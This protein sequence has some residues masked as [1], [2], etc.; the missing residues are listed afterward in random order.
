MNTWQNNLKAWEKQP[1]LKRLFLKF[2]KAEA[3]LVGGAVRDAIL[4]R[5]TK[6]FDLVIRQVAK[7]DLEKFLATQG[8]VNLVGKH[9]GVYKFRPRNWT[10]EEIDIA[11]PRTEYSLNQSGA[12]RDFKI[13]SQANLKIEDDLSRR[14]FTINAMAWDIKNKKI[15]DPFF[16]QSDLQ[17]K[18]IRTVGRPELRFKEDYS[19]LLRALRFSCQLSREP[20]AWEIE[21]TA[22]TAIKKNIKNLDKKI[23]GQ[24][25]VAYEVIAKELVKMVVSNPIWAIELLD[26][27]G[28]IKI[29]FPQLLKSKNCPQPKIYHSEG[30]VWEHMILAIQTLFTK[31]FKKEFKKPA[32]QEVIWAVIFHDIGKPFTLTMADRIRFNNH[33]VYSTNLFGQLSDKLKLTSAGLDVD[34]VKKLINK[35]MLTVQSQVLAMKDVTLEKYFFNPQF[36]GDELLMVM[37]AD[38]T[39]TVPPS[40]QPDYSSY[41]IL[42]KRLARLG[43]ANKNKKTLPKPLVTGGDLIKKFKLNSSPKIGDLLLI[44]REAQLKGKIKTKAQGLLFI[45][46]HIK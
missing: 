26:Q 42:K 33:D 35:H 37:F 27:C 1:F 24:R 34:K 9:F 16:G 39:A 43:K 2:P 14:D 5:E 21:T 17:Q 41:R 36:P 29:L 4:G 18:I 44:L 45:K 6:D 15:I 20:A 46:K 10:G 23:D 28:A 40:G 38:I 31:D 11:L 7:N 25:I 12:Y 30:D 3:Y 32:S 22:W 8:K 19:R 13:K